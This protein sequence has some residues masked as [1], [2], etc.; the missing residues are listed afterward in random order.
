MLDGSAICKGFEL[1]LTLNYS[2]KSNTMKPLAFTRLKIA[3]SGQI[4]NFLVTIHHSLI[5]VTKTVGYGV[6]P[7]ARQ[8]LPLGPCSDILD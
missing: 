2:N 5:K 4:Y 6:V 7:S 1:P 8:T 3:P